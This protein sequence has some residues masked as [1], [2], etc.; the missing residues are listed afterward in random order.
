MATLNTRIVLRND[1]S[2]NWLTNSKQVLLKGEVGIEFLTDGTVKMKVGDG[3]KTW[4]ELSYFGGEESHVYEATLET[5]ETKE[6]AIARVVGSNTPVVGDIAI[7][8]ALISGDKYEYTAYVCKETEDGTAW[9]AMDGNYNA[10]NVYFDKDFLFTYA[11]GKFSPDTTTGNVTVPALGKNLEDFFIGAHVDIKDP[12]ITDPNLSVSL[13]PA[14]ASGEV[15]TYYSIPTATAT[16][17][18]GSYSYG[19]TT[20]TSTSAGIVATSIKISDDKVNG[21]NSSTNSNSATYTISATSLP[22]TSRQIT[23]TAQSIKFS[24]ECSYPASSLQPVNNIG[25]SAD[26]D[27]NTYAAIDAGTDTASKTYS[28]TGYRKPFWGY[29]LTADALADPTKITSAQVRALGNSGTSV[30]GV[31]TTFTVPADTK[32]VYF[33]VKAGQKSSLTAVNKSA[34]SA[35]VAFTKVA[36]GVNVEGANGYTAVAYDLWYANFDE[37]TSGSAELGLTWK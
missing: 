28:I 23:D 8:K 29:K 13:S 35:P 18:A 26:E 27:G 21:E 20:S 34:L 15:G 11:F 6:A 7:V 14:S 10:K 9:A 2:A 4:E 25:E 36:S 17:T 33:A 22:E 30:G 12:T 31:P 32:Q 24:A 1:S 37:G 3:T 19:S 16:M 5:D